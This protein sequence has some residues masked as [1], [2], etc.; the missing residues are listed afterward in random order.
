MAKSLNPRDDRHSSSG[1]YDA[2]A[3]IPDAI[4]NE[5]LPLAENAISEVA[6]LIR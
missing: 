4:I 1:M 2:V 3:M 6:M 5:W